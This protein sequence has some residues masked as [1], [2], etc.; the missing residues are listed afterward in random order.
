MIVI[1]IGTLARIRKSLPLLLLLALF[2]ACSSSKKVS[3]LH[4]NGDQIVVLGFW[5]LENLFDTIDQ[6]GV[7]DSEFTPGGGK[8]YNTRIYRE[9]LGKLAEVI[10]KVGK[11]VSQ[12]GLAV[13]G[14]SEVENYSVLKD[15]VEQPAL[16]SAGYKVIH[17][18]SPD[19]RGIDVGLIYQPKY[20][21]PE[22]VTMHTV[23]L[24]NADGS[25]DYTRDVMQVDGKLLGEPVH[26]F[27][28]HWPSRSGGEEASRWRRDSAA[29]V[30]RRAIDAIFSAEPDAKIVIVGDFNDNPNNESL[31]KF[32]KAGPD[33]APKDKTKLYN[34]SYE[35]YK[36][37]TGSTAYRDAW[38]LFDQAIV[39]IPFLQDTSGWHFVKSGIFNRRFMINRMGKYK[40]YP[41]RSFVGDRWQ[42]GYSDHFPVFIYVVRSK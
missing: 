35:M 18:N 11:D 23:M 30:A 34:S 15:L 31:V 42:G 4:L 9:K 6:K 17:R 24:Y 1:M 3:S 2:F 28:N 40:G 25:R 27:V 32:L 5:N 22:A 36:G 16:K 33:Q 13:L 20:F 41:K 14:V 10:S 37:G 26:F 21:H 29:A 7:R 38:S 12:D 19:E 8:H 39:S